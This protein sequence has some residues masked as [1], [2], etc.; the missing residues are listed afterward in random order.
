[1]SVKRVPGVIKS[2]RSN[3][4]YRDHAERCS[5]SMTKKELSTMVTDLKKLDKKYH[6]DVYK[7]LRE[8][9]VPKKFFSSSASTVSFDITKLEEP[10]L[11]SLR[12]YLLFCK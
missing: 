1:M 5:A 3:D 2:L 9:G 7:F 11:Y 6:M 10:Q 8:N 4:G 12:R